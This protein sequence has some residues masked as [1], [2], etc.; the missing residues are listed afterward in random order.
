[1]NLHRN[2]IVFM[3]V[4]LLEDNFFMYI[5]A[6]GKVLKPTI[7][8]ED[9]TRLC[10]ECKKWKLQTSEFWY[11]DDG[12]PRGN[13]CKVCARLRYPSSS[14]DIDDW[15]VYKEPHYYFNAE[16][17]RIGHMALNAMGWTWNESR[18]IWTKPGVVTKDGKWVGMPA[19]VESV[20]T[21]IL[22]DEQKDEIRTTYKKGKFDEFLSKYNINSS[23][24]KN[25]LK[26]KPSGT[27][28]Q[29]SKQGSKRGRNPDP[30]VPRKPDGTIIYEL[31]NRKIPFRPRLTQEDRDL[32]ISLYAVNT[33]IIDICAELNRSATTVRNCKND[34][35]RDKRK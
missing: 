2:E 17:R 14:K 10:R 29:G 3:N 22:T 32:I 13:F 8:K 35:E 34:Y 7:N 27:G 31:P 23:R 21:R 19:D 20:G 11:V 24:L 16:Q 4:R 28:K 33:P 26:S 5:L 15:R 12:K 18:K 30:N 9:N 6:M 25:I 1:M